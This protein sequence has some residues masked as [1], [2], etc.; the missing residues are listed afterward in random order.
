MS[1]N[2]GAEDNLEGGVIL[3]DLLRALPTSLSRRPPEALSWHHGAWATPDF[4]QI[5]ASIV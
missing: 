4:R 5:S 1:C 3:T 2:A